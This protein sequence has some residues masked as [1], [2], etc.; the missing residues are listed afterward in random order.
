MAG[1]IH[2]YSPGITQSG[3]FWTVA[4]PPEAVHFDPDLEA[5]SYRLTNLKVV[6]AF[7]LVNALAGGPDVPASISFEVEWT[8]TGPAKSSRHDAHG[9]KGEFRKAKARV[10]WSGSTKDSSYLSQAADTSNS[11]FAFI[12]RERNGVFFS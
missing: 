1:Q 12:G 2:D 9:Y 10:A 5:A 11:I 8:A 4:V 6:D 7:N 3:L